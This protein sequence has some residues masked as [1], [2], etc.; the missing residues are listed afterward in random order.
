MD[1]KETLTAAEVTRLVVNTT[2]LPIRPAGKVIDLVSLFVGVHF[3]T[4]GNLRSFAILRGTPI[5]VH[6]FV[7]HSVN[8]KANAGFKKAIEM[9]PIKVLADAAARTMFDAFT[10]WLVFKLVLGFGCPVHYLM[11]VSRI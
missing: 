4:L 8:R 7:N 10:D 6:K 1:I 11:R 2:L 3:N 9:R 5:A